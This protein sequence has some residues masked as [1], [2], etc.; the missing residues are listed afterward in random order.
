MPAV[1]LKCEKPTGPSL[2]VGKRLREG[3]NAPNCA[4]NGPEVQ[5]KKTR[6]YSSNHKVLSKSHS[7]LE[8]LSLAR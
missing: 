8:I 6:D 2:G 4:T 1:A 3:V 7:D 5:S